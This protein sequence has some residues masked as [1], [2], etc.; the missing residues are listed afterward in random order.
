MNRLCAAPRSPLSSAPVS[1]Q[2]S[3][4]EPSDDALDEDSSNEPNVGDIMAIRDQFMREGNIPALK[5]NLGRYWHV[6]VNLNL[7]WGIDQA[8]FDT[9]M[10][11]WPAPPHTGPRLLL[12]GAAHVDVRPE[13][14]AGLFCNPRITR[15]ELV[16]VDLHDDMLQAVSEAITRNGTALRDFTFRHD[17]A[18]MFS[19]GLATLLARLLKLQTL[20]LQLTP[21][22]T[23]RLPTVTECT[24]LMETLL[25]KPLQDLCL[26]NFGGALRQMIPHW[27]TGPYRP[28]WKAVT[29]ENHNL[30]FNA[31]N[32]QTESAF[33]GF[34]AFVHHIIC[35]S[36]A[37]MLTLKNLGSDPLFAWRADPPMDLTQ[38]CFTRLRQAL[39]SALFERSRQAGAQPLDVIIGMVDL[40]VL[41]MLLPAFAF[42]HPSVKCIQSLALQWTPP[43]GPAQPAPPPRPW[44]NGTDEASMQLHAGSFLQLVAKHVGH[45]QRIED[46]CIRVDLPGSATHPAVRDS[47]HALSQVL[48]GLHLTALEFTGNWFDE[49]PDALQNC[50]Q[51]AETLRMHMHLQQMALG[52][53]MRFGGE[54]YPLLGEAGSV[55][56]EHHGHPDRLLP[57]L[58]A[59]DSL[60][61]KA[62][63][64]R[65]EARRTQLAQLGEPCLPPPHPLKTLSDSVQQRVG[66]GS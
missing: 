5:D 48:N 44:D 38:A 59:L 14:I 57:V 36:Q 54:R 46:L 24:W 7:A 64:D 23:D 55:V 8:R 19:P 17:S 27:S 65:Y 18:H 25:A 29:I 4:R 10:A 37:S 34:S 12:A 2:G 30:G 28:R 31:Q 52:S 43:Q 13:W 47:V 3:P 45:L 61:L 1:L 66:G 63:V 32:R 33:R 20:H 49:V 58:P 62:F 56:L 51:A 6:S 15:L 9:L 26:D 22:P 50:M 40:G 42:A 41:R 35:R 16:S 39:R 53:C 60:H 11:A 21:A